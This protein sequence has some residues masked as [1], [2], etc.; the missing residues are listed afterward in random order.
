MSLLRR[1][2]ISSGKLD[3]GGGG[4]PF[5]PSVTP[6]LWLDT[7]V[8]IFNDAGSTAASDNDTIQEWHDF[9][10]NGEE[11]TQ[12][13]GASRPTYKTSI[14]NGQPIL[15]YDGSSDALD[16]TAV[17]A[18]SSAAHIF[19]VVKLDY[20]AASFARLLD[21]SNSWYIF[22]NDTNPYRN[23]NITYDK[24]TSGPSILGIQ[25][26]DA[27]FIDSNF[28]L[29]E[30]RFDGTGPESPSSYD[31]DHNEVSLTPTNGGNFSASASANVLGHT[32]FKG[33]MGDVAMYG[34]VLTGTDRTEWI[35][36]LTD[37]WGL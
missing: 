21:M 15:R 29:L 27:T 33:D 11:A 3:A 5:V 9:N 20:V 6:D 4:G 24:P 28:G 31:I 8:N 17:F 34:Q 26:V 13:A 23:I 7:S 25:A 36:H 1:G 12:T 30:I 19:M 10:T 16:L 22:A 2:I 37:K 14:Q 32:T 35:T 18:S